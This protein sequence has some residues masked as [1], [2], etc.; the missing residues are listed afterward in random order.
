MGQEPCQR[1]RQGGPN[2]WDPLAAA[3]ERHRAAFGGKPGV[4]YFAQGNR[5][6]LIGLIKRAIA[7]GTPLDDAET[8]R[9]L[10]L[11]PPPP[12]AVT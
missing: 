7:R 11:D 8:Y 4:F 10:G 1:Q 6:K 3:I 2:G 5:E 9:E 12:D